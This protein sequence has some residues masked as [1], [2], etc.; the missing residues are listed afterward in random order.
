MLSKQHN[1]NH[2]LRTS[3][4]VLFGGLGECVR[5]IIRSLR[6]TAA[7][8]PSRWQGIAGTQPVMQSATSGFGIERRFYSDMP[9]G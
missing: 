3:C 2:L 5:T 6:P 1:L 7:V 9:R 8:E 4:V